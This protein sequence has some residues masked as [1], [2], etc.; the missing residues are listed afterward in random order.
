MRKDTFL[1]LKYYTIILTVT[2]KG[3]QAKHYLKDINECNKILEVY[4]NLDTPFDY[5][6]KEFDTWKVKKGN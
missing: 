4:K 5:T 3:K 1:N 6:I 2:L